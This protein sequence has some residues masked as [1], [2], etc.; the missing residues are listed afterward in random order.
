MLLQSHVGDSENG[1]LLEFLPAL[2]G[3]WPKGSVEGLRARGGFT[4]DLRWA[5][6]NVQE[7][8]LQH[9]QNA[10]ARI[11]IDGQERTVVADGSWQQP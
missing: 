11:A 10:K 1:Y 7:F 4:V 3:T 6:G 8:R 5:D 9:P 2:P